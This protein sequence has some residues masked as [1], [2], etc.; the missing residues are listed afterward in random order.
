MGKGK[1]KGSDDS[2]K[3][4]GSD[5]RGKG[6]GFDDKGKGKGANAKGKGKG[7][8][9][10]DLGTAIWGHQKPLKFYRDDGT[11]KQGFG[12]RKR[13]SA[14]KLLEKLN[15]ADEMGINRNDFR[16]VESFIRALLDKYDVIL[17]GTFTEE[18]SA[19][20]LRAGGLPL[21]SPAHRM[22]LDECVNRLRAAQKVKEEVEEEEK[23]EEEEVAKKEDQE[24]ANEEEEQEVANEENPSSSSSSAAAAVPQE[25]IY[26]PSSSSA[27][28]AVP[29]ELIYNPSSSSSSSAVAAVPQEPRK[30]SRKRKKIADPR[31][32]ADHDEK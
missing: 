4:K 23:E 7:K 27:A 6:K 10:W 20:I 28:A 29:Q 11:S 19:G 12:A 3:G 32:A 15:V 25:L 2:G 14:K 16:R 17:A 5:D 22:Q 24:V 21:D 18:D 13:R 31:L 30:I 26:N 1:G 9:K 8:S